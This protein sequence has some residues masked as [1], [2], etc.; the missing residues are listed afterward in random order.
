MMFFFAWMSTVTPDTVQ[1]LIM[2]TDHWQML[3]AKDLCVEYMQR[4]IDAQNCLGKD[5]NQ[6][7]ITFIIVC[8][9]VVIRYILI[10]WEGE[11]M[12]LFMFSS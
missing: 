3:D 12:W 9:I 2:A 4:Q 6:I 8:T 10:G 1:S 7:L 5:Q 11:K